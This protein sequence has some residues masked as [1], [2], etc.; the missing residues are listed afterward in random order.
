[1]SPYILDN[2]EEKAIFYYGHPRRYRVRFEGCG[3]NLWTKDTDFVAKFMQMLFQEEVEAGLIVP[4]TA[5]K[6]KRCQPQSKVDRQ[7][8]VSDQQVADIASGHKMST[9][10]RK[11][12][13]CR[14]QR[15]NNNRGR[16][17]C[18]CGDWKDRR[19]DQRRPTWQC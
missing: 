15:D 1:M 4:A 17:N 6:L 16:N 8:A 2:L 19:C 13:R 3:H 5:E 10:P 7:L 18:R 12:E 14:S 9:A 11:Q